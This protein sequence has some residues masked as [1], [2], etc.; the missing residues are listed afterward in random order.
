MHA[1]QANRARIAERAG[2]RRNAG[3]V[4]IDPAARSAMPTHP[5]AAGVVRRSRAL[6]M[7]GAQRN[8]EGRISEWTRSPDYF[9]DPAWAYTVS[10]QSR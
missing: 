9:T 6:P 4:G 5:M 7:T 2:I 8:S 3:P 1:S 10:E